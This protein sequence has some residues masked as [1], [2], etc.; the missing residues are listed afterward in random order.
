MS[1]QWWVF[2][3]TGKSAFGGV[4]FEFKCREC[5]QRFS[6]RSLAEL[7]DECPEC[8]CGVTT[9]GCMSEEKAI[10]ALNTRPKCHIVRTPHPSYPNSGKCS[11]CGWSSDYWVD[12]RFARCPGC[13]AE[14]ER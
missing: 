8:G 6:A 11:E 4:W 2:C 13:G 3:D 1:E 10:D 7:P 9:I 14:V 12:E 5:G